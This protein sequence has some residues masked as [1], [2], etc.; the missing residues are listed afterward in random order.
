[1]RKLFQGLVRE[2]ARQLSGRQRSASQSDRLS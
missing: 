2:Q 1:M